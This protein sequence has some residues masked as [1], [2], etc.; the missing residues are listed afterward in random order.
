M[1]RRSRGFTLIEIMI[2]ITIMAMLAAIMIPNFK[3]ARAR[4]QLSN[5]VGNCKNLATVLELYAVDN[6]G[7]FPALAGL[8]GIDKVIA[9]GGIKLRPTC[10]SAGT[11]TFVDFQ[12]TQT[13]DRFSFSCVGNNHS[14]AWPGLAA[15]NLPSY[16]NDGGVVMEP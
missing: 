9:N 16:S 4:A 3:H 14:E 6:D 13:P 1:Q 15:G 11:C 7:R 8:P 5:C 10:P 2:V 12:T